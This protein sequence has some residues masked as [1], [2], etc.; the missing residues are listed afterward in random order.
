MYI[1]QCIL[2]KFHQGE[3]AAKEWKSICYFPGKCFVSYDVCVAV[4]NFPQTQEEIDSG[5]LKTVSTRLKKREKLRRWVPRQLNQKRETVHVDFITSI[6][7]T[8]EYSSRTGFKSMSRLDEESFQKWR[9]AF[10][11]YHVVE[12]FISCIFHYTVIIR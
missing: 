2:C 4:E 1:R 9:V 8:N 12:D 3:T 7:R 10:H 6:L 5:D 11:E